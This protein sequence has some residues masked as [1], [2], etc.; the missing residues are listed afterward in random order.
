MNV[1]GLADFL[2]SATMQELVDT[3][4]VMQNE[5]RFRTEKRDEEQEKNFDWSILKSSPMQ[6]YTWSGGEPI[7][8]DTDNK[9]L[10]NLLNS[11]RKPL[12]RNIDIK[13]EIPLDPDKKDNIWMYTNSYTTGLIR[14]E[15]YC[16]CKIL[17]SN[18]LV[19][20]WFLKNIKPDIVIHETCN[21]VANIV[22]LIREYNDDKLNNLV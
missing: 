19:F 2:Q 16:S 12:S 15:D 13:R 8:L 1:N 21:A 18:I 7:S 4:Q 10:Y 11:R 22:N 9:P 6:I 17:F 3:I 20:K 14:G 5:I